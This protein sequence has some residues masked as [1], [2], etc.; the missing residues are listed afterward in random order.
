MVNEQ[1]TVERNL[2]PALVFLQLQ[3]RA[4]QK[5]SEQDTFYA[6]GSQK[7]IV[8][9][10]SSDGVLVEKKLSFHSQWRISSISSSQKK[11]IWIQWEVKKGRERKKWNEIATVL[12]CLLSFRIKIVE[13]YK[14]REIVVKSARA[15]RR[16]N[17]V[18]VLNLPTYSV[19]V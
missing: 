7:F 11:R 17:R 18:K 5:D 9:G 14:V 2:K 15:K 4:G 10:N 1:A 8:N 19:I 16:I 13:E 6:V 12:Q 3:N